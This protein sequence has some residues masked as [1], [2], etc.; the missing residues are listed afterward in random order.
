MLE[1]ETEDTYKFSDE[2]QKTL[3]STPISQESDATYFRCL[4]EFLYK[5][6]LSVL[7]NRSVTGRTP[8]KGPEFK[9]ISP[10]KKE[11]IFKKFSER[12]QNP[13]VPLHEKVNRLNTNYIGRKIAVAIGTIRKSTAKEN[14]ASKKMH[15]LSG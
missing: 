11:I 14:A 9:C 4:L 13:K 6:D 7:N 15:S 1:L 3:N 2:E 8:K 10:D 12:L 5:D